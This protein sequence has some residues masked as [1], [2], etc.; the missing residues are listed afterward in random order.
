MHLFQ[1]LSKKKSLNFQYQVSEK[2][3][4]GHCEHCVLGTCSPF[5]LV[6]AN[7]MVILQKPFAVRKHGD[8]GRT[9]LIL[10]V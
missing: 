2:R 5:L 8:A 10:S 1:D 9:P 7:C 6:K 4:S 3:N